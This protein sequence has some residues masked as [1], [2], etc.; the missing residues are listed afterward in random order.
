MSDERLKKLFTEGVAAYRAGQ[1]DRAATA[2]EDLLART[3]DHLNALQLLGLLHY[4]RSRWREGETCFRRVLQLRPDLAQSWFNLAKV[5]AAQGRWA[6]AEKL[7]R[8]GLARQPNDARAM[9]HLGICLRELGRLE[10]AEVAHR[11]ATELDPKDPAPI[12]NLGAVQLM[13]GQT[14]AAAGSFARAA[15]INPAL[16]ETHGNLGNAVREMMGASEAHAAFERAVAVRPGY[17]LGWIGLLLNA[18]YHPDLSRAEKFLLH[19]RFATWKRSEIGTWDTS[20]PPRPPGPR[21]HIGY[22][23]SELYQHAVAHFLWPIFRHHDRTR[24]EISVFANT[25]HE[26]AVTAG[27]R[28]GADHWHSICG[29][30]DAEATALIRDCHV[31]IIVDLNGHSGFSRLGIFARKAAPI[32]VTY[33]GYPDTTGLSE[34][35]YRLTDDVADPPGQGDEFYAETLWRLPAPAWCYEPPSGA[36]PAAVAKPAHAP[37]VFGC[38]NNSAKLNVRLL[39]WWS[40]ILRSLSDSRLV[41]KA[42]TFSDPAVC[43]KVRKIFSD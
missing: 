22:V 16:A 26:D 12:N 13:L 3:P 19:G 25:Y 5:T 28:A 39:G 27:L 38:F 35:D 23:S 21:C 29:R 41:L 7:D 32:Q 20:L 14:M 31:D 33:L 24:F 1:F 6:E 30:S 15:E 10:E 37:V 8:E 36:P 42:R 18:Q 4:Q 17:A 2:W 11:R 40:E 43:A 34:I 9:D